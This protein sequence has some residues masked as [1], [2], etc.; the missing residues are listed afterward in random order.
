MRNAA[1]ALEQGGNIA[2]RVAATQDQIQ[3]E[4]AD[5]EDE[6]AEFYAAMARLAEG[7]LNQPDE[8]RRCALSSVGVFD[9]PIRDAR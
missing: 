2:L 8:A 3:L 7:P 9:E 5:S 1:E 6:R 4:V